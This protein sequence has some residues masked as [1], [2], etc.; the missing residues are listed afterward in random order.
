MSWDKDE[1]TSST[2]VATLER[3]PEHALSSSGTAGV[4][5]MYRRAFQE[6]FRESIL[7]VAAKYLGAIS[8]LGY[9]RWIQYPTQ[10]TYGARLPF[11]RALLERE[12]AHEQ[13]RRAYLVHKKHFGELDAEE[14]VELERLDAIE[15]AAIEAESAPQLE[16]ARRLLNFA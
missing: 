7:T 2:A 8:L 4:R 10:E 11:M 13:E 5:A 9:E 14:R 15:D 1:G 16:F 3:K 12:R 6:D